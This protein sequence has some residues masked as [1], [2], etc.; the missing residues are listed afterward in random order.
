[1]RCTTW[2]FRA[3]RIGSR[4]S[5]RSRCVHAPRPCSHAPRPVCPCAKAV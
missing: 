5:S 2:P 4:A 3:T 1:V